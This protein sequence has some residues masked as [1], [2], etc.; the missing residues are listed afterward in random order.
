[1]WVTSIR[2]VWCSFCWSLTAMNELR[3]HNETESEAETG[4]RRGGKVCFFEGQ[5]R[6]RVVWVLTDSILLLSGKNWTHLS[7]VGTMRTKICSLTAMVGVFPTKQSD[8]LT[9]FLE[10]LKPA[11]TRLTHSGAAVFVD[12]GFEGV[13]Y[14]DCEGRRLDETNA[15]KMRPAEYVTSC[16]RPRSC[17]R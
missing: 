9:R 8:Y 6:A 14:G 3:P 17:F 15:S 2:T 13:A 4:R 12:H 11:W 7:K 1:M 5:T 16:S 10:H